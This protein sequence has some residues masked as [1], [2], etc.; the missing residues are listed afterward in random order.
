MYLSDGIL[1]ETGRRL[2]KKTYFSEDH[3]LLLYH[4]RLKKLKKNKKVLNLQD[5]QRPINQIYTPIR[6][7]LYI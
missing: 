2:D 1:S 6:F 3:S 4:M 5:Q 7:F